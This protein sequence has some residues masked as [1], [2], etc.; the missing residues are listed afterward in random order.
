MSTTRFCELLDISERPWRRWQASQRPLANTVAGPSPG[1][2]GHDVQL[3]SRLGPSQDLGHGPSRQAPGVTVDGV[4]DHGRRGPAL[5]ADYQ[6]QCRELAKQH[7]AAFAA[8]PNGPNQVWQ[9][10]FS[11]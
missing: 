5:R 7:K 3:T 1:G 8:Q 11:E 2:R 6:K 4:A 9:F 10:D